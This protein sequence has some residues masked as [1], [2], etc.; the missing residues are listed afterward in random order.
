MKE[1]IK[2][3][4]YVARRFK[5]ATTLNLAGLVVAFATFYLLMTQ[6]I[7]QNS[8]NHGIEDYKH[9][10]RMESDNVY[11]EWDFSNLVCR[12]FADALQ[13]LPEV[14]SYSLTY[15]PGY[16]SYTKFRFLKGDQE[17]PDTLTYSMFPCNNTATSTLTSKKLNGS[18]EWTDGDQD[19]IIIPASIAMEYFGT[20]EVA[21][22][23]MLAYYPDGN[24][25]FTVRG[26]YEDFP[27]NSELSNG[28]F[29]NMLSRDSLEL[30]AGYQCI[31]KF[32]TIPD[33]MAAF[34]RKLKQ[35]II[36][37]L[38]E[39]LKA[40]GMESQLTTRIEEVKM[41]NIKFTPLKDSYF[42]HSSFT[43][44][45][46][47]Y[48]GWVHLLQLTSLLVLIIA[49]INFLNFTLAESP[50]RIRSL[51]TRLVHGASR[52]ALWL[53][54][55]G[56]GIITSL[57]ACCLALIVC[58]LLQ[59]IPFVNKLTLGSLALEDHSLLV[60]AMLVLAVI[61]GI[62]A[63][64]YPGRF[65]TSIPPA[66]ALRSSFGLTPQG[67]RLRK[68]LIGMQLCISMLMIIY[69]GMLYRQ[70]QFIFNSDYGY[71]SRQ[72]IMAELPLP[73]TY[74]YRADNDSLYHD[75]IQLPGV[76]DVAFSE[77]QLGQ[78][79]GH[80]TVWTSQQ[81]ETFK[82]SLMHVSRNYLSTMGI[83]IADGHDFTPEDTLAVIINEAV[84][85]RWHWLDLGTRI[86]TGTS[87]LEPDST[88]VVGVIENI[89]Y[90]TIR[91][92]NSQPF[93]FVFKEGYDLLGNMNVRVS[94]Q[95]DRQAVKRQINDL[96]TKK[97][98][99]Q[100]KPAEFFN[101][102]LIHTY[103]N[104]FR[105]VNQMVII[106]FICLIITLIG[107]FCLTL[108]ETEYR[109]KEI[110]IRKISGATSR[111]II[112]LLCKQYIKHIL[113][114][115]VIAAP[116]AILFG[117]FTLNYFKQHAPIDWWLFPVALLLVSGITLG[118]VML[119][120]LRAAR[121]NPVNSIRTE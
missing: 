100:A 19:G 55:I 92:N 107:V 47:G 90:G 81:E 22:K 57:V 49:A 1:T 95:A 35:A 116:L 106:C 39:G 8:F 63:S 75:I 59:F 64:A 111:E 108:F 54:I 18:I 30:E 83:K 45:D 89:R 48:R 110:G 42:E 41:T 33:D 97:Y 85:N 121:E 112:W 26:V 82:Y 62:V 13:R 50:M 68:L 66:I 78:T 53:S 3:L 91:I 51:N 118:T 101:D 98:G 4:I 67:K 2:N 65:A 20:L 17:V 6:V 9:L 117:L 96:L 103:D 109:R 71:D 29:F 36:D 80:S 84:R 58:R 31:V 28:I 5:L 52:R 12:P 32:K 76:E 7:Y 23:E 16:E 79:D 120:S 113:I 94:P 88:P 104:E 24:Y 44:S 119:Q 87:Y 38:T 102:L 115:F 25:P 21:G 14:E 72:I 86:S 114:A 70:S 15:N 105:Y 73:S 60:L 93:S 37:H 74:D 27:Q 56:E 10:Y 43:P 77:A 46:R 40:E 69:I 34:T 99:P 61:V 11:N